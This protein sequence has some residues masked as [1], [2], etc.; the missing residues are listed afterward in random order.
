MS[1]SHP[2]TADQLWKTP[3]DGMRHELV[4]G[5]LKIMSPAGSEHGAIIAEITAFLLPFVKSHKL[6]TVFGAETGFKIATDPDTVRAPDVAFV[7]RERIPQTGL[8]KAFWPGAP[9]LA[10][11]VVSPG[12][13]VDEVD[14]KVADW[15]GAGTKVVW[16]VKPKTRTVAVHF[17]PNAQ[18]I[19][20]ADEEIDGGELVPGFRCRVGDLF[21]Q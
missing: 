20:T 8:P 9:D 6:G 2:I 21:P 19:L 18:T 12:D 1:I 10:V 7:R 4:R 14:E 16:I 5:E 3:R 15:L 13:T 17:A 11:E